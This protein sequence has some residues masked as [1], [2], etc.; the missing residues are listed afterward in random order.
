MPAEAKV[1]RKDKRIIVENVRRVLLKEYLMNETRRAGFG[2]LDIQRT[3]MGTRVTLLAERPGLVIGRKGGAIK[4]LTEAVEQRFRFDNPQIEVQEVASPALNAQI[5]AE[6]LANALERGG[7][8]EADGR[9]PRRRSRRSARTDSGTGAVGRGRGRG[10]TRER[11]VRRRARTAHRPGGAGSGEEGQEEQS[12][13]EAVEEGR[14]TGERTRRRCRRGDRRRRRD[15][16]A[17]LRTKEI[18]AM[19]ADTIAKKL[20]ELRDEL[21]HERG[22]AA[23]GGAPPNPGKIRA[24]RKNIARILTIMREEELAGGGDHPG[25]APAAETAPAGRQDGQRTSRNTSSSAFGW[26]SSTRPTPAR[27]MS[28][29]PSSM[30]RATCSWSRGKGRESGSRS[31]G[32]DSVSMSPA[33]SKSTETRSDSDR[34]TA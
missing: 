14:Q 20:T 4:A 19:D 26:R 33:D 15:V 18:R 30:R 22:V 29:G 16:M 27:N 34:K 7:D 1:N 23:M 2:G 21:M 9:I 11:R 10:R 12:R 31:M 13:D 5:M 32:A 24:L 3:P 28:A 8:Q 17:L 6:K 25:E